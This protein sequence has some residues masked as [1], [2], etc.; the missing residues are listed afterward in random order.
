MTIEIKNKGLVIGMIVG[1][2]FITALLAIWVYQLKP[3]N[4]VAG[5]PPGFS[6]AQATSS[7]ITIA[8]YDTVEVFATSTCVTR[9]VSSAPT[10]MRFLLWDTT[11]RPSA[12]IGIKHNASTT[13]AYEGSVWGCG[14][15]RFFNNSASTTIFTVTELQGF[16]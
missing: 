7:Q 9:V 5:A 14:K 13:V 15:W 8:G 4:A 2:M 3:Q 10:D 12:G 16:Q 11:D 1:F 6:A